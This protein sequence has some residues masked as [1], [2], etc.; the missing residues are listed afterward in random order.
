MMFAI[1]VGEFRTHCGAE[2]SGGLDD[3]G[4]LMQQ[5]FMVCR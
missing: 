5:S 3:I 4:R 2:P 1:E